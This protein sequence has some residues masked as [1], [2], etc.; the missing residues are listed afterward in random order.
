MTK[1]R[2][3]ALVFF[4]ATGDL[5]YKKIFPALQNMV[6]HG[7]LDVRLI[8]VARAGWSC[9]QLLD[10]VRDSLNEYGGG[11]DEAAFSRLAQRLEY[12][13]GDYADPTTFRKLRGALGN[14]QRP[15]HYLA[16]PPS[17]FGAVVQALGGSWGPPEAEQ[18]AHDLGGWRNPE[19]LV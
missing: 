11:V 1:G 14:A 4:A 2:S 3:D 9:D 15:T 18:L 6:R 16:I 7:T 8:G 19:V 12:V 17:R 13:S 5:A 10:R